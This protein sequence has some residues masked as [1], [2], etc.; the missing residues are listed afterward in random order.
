[1]GQLPPDL[2]I[3]SSIESRKQKQKI[4][5]R[6]TTVRA[7]RVFRSLAPIITLLSNGNLN[8][9]TFYII[10][11]LLF[12]GVRRSATRVVIGLDLSSRFDTDS[13][14]YCLL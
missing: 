14:I 12:S 5:K 7:V 3:E 13:L 8:S 10:F 11:L 9:R 4:R 1:M 2:V 6:Q